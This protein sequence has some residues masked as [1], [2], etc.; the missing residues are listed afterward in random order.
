MIT[1]LSSGNEHTICVK[2]SALSL[3]DGRC[4]Q[5]SVKYDQVRLADYW[6]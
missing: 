6:D 3:A 1:H 2:V 4:G 5:M